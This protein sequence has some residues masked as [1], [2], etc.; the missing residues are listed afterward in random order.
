MICIVLF[1]CYLNSLSYGFY[2][3]SDGIFSSCD[4]YRKLTFVFYYIFVLIY[5][6]FACLTFIQLI[7]GCILL[8]LAIMAM[9][10]SLSSIHII[11]IGIL[12]DVVHIIVGG[13]VIVLSVNILLF[14]ILLFNVFILGFNNY[15]FVECND[16]DQNIRCLSR[17]LKLQYLSSEG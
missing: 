12:L 5:F 8:I 1:S 6:Q 7:T 15:F 14:F 13:S 10:V 9:V 11:R 4:F 2:Y 17:C 16:I 3:C